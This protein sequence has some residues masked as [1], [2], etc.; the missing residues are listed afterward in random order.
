MINNISGN[1]N[2][3]DTIHNNEA[4]SELEGKRKKIVQTMNNHVIDLQ[5]SRKIMNNF[6]IQ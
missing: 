2:A 5:Y 4:I 1:L 6:H 3:E